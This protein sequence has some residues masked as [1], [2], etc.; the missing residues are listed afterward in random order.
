MFGG[1]EA[2]G[3]S[4]GAKL[5]Q[6]YLAL[7]VVDAGSP[8][9]VAFWSVLLD[10]AAEEVMQAVQFVGSGVFEVSQYLRERQDSASALL[11]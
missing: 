1:Q 4:T 7:P 9:D 11:Q 5:A 3:T 8:Q 10:V 2:E 6:S